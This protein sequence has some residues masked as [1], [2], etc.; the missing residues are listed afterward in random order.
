MPINNVYKLVLITDAGAFKSQAH[1]ERTVIVHLL[2]RINNSHS[3][4]GFSVGH[5]V[6]KQDIDENEIFAELKINLEKQ[7]QVMIA[8]MLTACLQSHKKLL[9]NFSYSIDERF[10]SEKKQ[11]SIN[12]LN[13]TSEFVVTGY[14][15]NLMNKHNIEVDGFL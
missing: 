1:H 6:I 5:G 12:R 8:S 10:I 2:D 3:L 14:G 7:H 4:D 9:F 13:I 11:L 15:L